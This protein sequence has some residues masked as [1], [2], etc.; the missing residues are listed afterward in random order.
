MDILERLKE[1]A[2]GNWPET[3]LDD[4]V[5]EAADEI[6]KLRAENADLHHD[7]ARHVQIA[8]ELATDNEALRRRMGLMREWMNQ[9]HLFKT[10][11]PWAV[12]AEFNPEAAT[13][14]TI[15]YEKKSVDQ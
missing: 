9:Q 1:W 11:T 7:I 6:Q 2:V 10:Q 15:D 3:S 5:G 13:W 14:F 12:F 4:D 8:A